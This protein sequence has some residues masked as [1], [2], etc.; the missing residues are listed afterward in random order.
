MTPDEQRI[1]IA[2]WVGYTFPQIE[3]SGLMNV[4]IRLNEELSDPPPDYPNNL[5]SIHEAEGKLIFSRRQAYYHELQ[6]V[7]SRGMDVSC[8][9]A[10]IE[11]CR[12]T[13]SQRSEALLRT[14]GKWKED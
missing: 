14:I 9:I 13:A 6:K 11:C 7:M 2:R 5:N 12:A 4:E 10:E 8:L 3:V 1:A